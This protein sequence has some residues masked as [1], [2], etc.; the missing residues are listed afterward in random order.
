MDWLINKMWEVSCIEIDQSTAQVSI[1]GS[2]D[3]GSFYFY[4]DGTF[5]KYESSNLAICDPTD[6]TFSYIIIDQGT[7]NGTTG[8]PFGDITGGSGNSTTSTW[9]F[10]QETL[11]MN[12]YGSW[13]IEERSNHEIVMKSSRT[14]YNFVYRLVSN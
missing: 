9:N 10:N 3:Y 13:K 8:I 11:I 4:S 5:K 14:G 2:P 12:Q 6:T 1:E 7:G